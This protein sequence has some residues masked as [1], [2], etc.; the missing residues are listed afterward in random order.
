MDC[1]NRPTHTFDLPENAVDKQMS[2]GRI[3]PELPFIKKKAVEL[4]K[5]NY[6]ARDVAKER[7]I[8]ELNKFYRDELPTDLSR[9]DA[10]LCRS[11]R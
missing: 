3:S 8:E 2:L 1:H 10:L 4:L 11:G 6:P 9:R 7:I 5:V